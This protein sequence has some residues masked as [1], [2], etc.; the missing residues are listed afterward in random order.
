MRK[1]S[2][3]LAASLIAFSACQ[4]SY[5]KGEEGMEYKIISNGSGE[6]VKNGQFMEIHFNNLLTRT[7]KKDSTL[8][9]TRE[10][11]SPQIVP[12]DSAQLP[13][14][15]YKLFKQMKKGDSLSTRTLVDSLFKKNPKSMPPFMKTGDYVYT[16][17]TLNNIYKTQQ[18]ADSAKNI[19]MAAAEKNW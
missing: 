9:S 6:T 11:G 19:A 2:Y 4:T 12:F 5:K 10:M 18:A 16:N 8:A 14:A 7:G 17:I 13:P 3:L 1:I 15:Y